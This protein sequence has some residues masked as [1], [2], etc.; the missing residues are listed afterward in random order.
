MIKTI[1]CRL[2]SGALFGAFLMLFLTDSLNIAAQSEYSRASLWEDEIAEFKQ[3]DLENPPKEGSILFIGSSSF[4]GW[5][6]LKDDFSEYKVI[7]RSFGGSHL[8]DLIYY[9]DDL[10]L[11]YKPCQIIVYEGDN[12]VASGMTPK[13]YLQDVVTFSRMV[14]VFLPESELAFV[15]IKPSPAREKWIEEYQEANNLVREFCISKPNMKFIDVSQLMIDREGKIKEEYFM[16]DMLHM[17]TLGYQLWKK[18]ILPY[19]SEKG[20][21]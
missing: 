9:F 10:I 11:P 19:L 15:S 5:R 8:S 6:S 3:R 2:G 18:V 16:S 12:D 17:K 14:E 13:E 20:K 7:N 1:I 21:N 4:R